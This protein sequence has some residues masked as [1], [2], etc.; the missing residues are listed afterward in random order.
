[1]PL[2]MKLSYL[3]ISGINWVVMIKMCGIYQ[4]PLIGKVEMPYIS[5]HVYHHLKRKISTNL[6]QPSTRNCPHLIWCSATGRQEFIW[7]WFCKQCNSLY[8]HMC[9]SSQTFTLS[10]RGFY[11]ILWWK[12]GNCL[13]K[14]VSLTVWQSVVKLL[15]S[16]TLLWFLCCSVYIEG[17]FY[18]EFLCQKWVRWLDHFILL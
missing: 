18:L 9:S 4:W 15:T 14:P 3:F 1:M 7:S 16:F 10:H 2:G 6:P 11:T 8:D 17:H 13:E 5:R 12:Q